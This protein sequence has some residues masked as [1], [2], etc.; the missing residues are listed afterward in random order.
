MSHEELLQLFE[1][2]D[3]GTINPFDF[4]LQI[5][6]HN[7]STG[8]MLTEVD[9]IHHSKLAIYAYQNNVVTIKLAD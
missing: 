6:M 5:N 1:S 2:Y 3:M 7:I 8:Q 9:V 4:I